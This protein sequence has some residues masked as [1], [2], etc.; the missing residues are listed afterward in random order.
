MIWAVLRDVQKGANP[1][2]LFNR[3]RNR[4]RPKGTAIDRARGVIAAACHYLIKGGESRD[5]A[6]RFIAAELRHWQVKAPNG[7]TITSVRVLGWRDEM[8][9]RASELAT[10]TY[11]NVLSSFQEAMGA[12][13]AIDKDTR[14]K[15]VAGA[16][17]ALH[18]SG[19]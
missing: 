10:R 1:P 7:S 5:E 6:S 4:G 19:F 15:W 3:E 8:G 17:H 13:D 18:G 12:A 16:I 14:R 11:R 2:L 9:G